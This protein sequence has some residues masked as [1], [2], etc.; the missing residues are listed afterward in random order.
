MLK[1]ISNSFLVKSVQGR[2]C[3]AFFTAAYAFVFC[4]I[5]SSISSLKK[6]LNILAGEE[7]VSIKI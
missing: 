1:K 4:V 3:P 2:P 5:V 6:R 7:L